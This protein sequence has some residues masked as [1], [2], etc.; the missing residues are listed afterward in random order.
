MSLAS[1]WDSV[2]QR[3]ISPILWNL[4]SSFRFESVLLALALISIAGFLGTRQV[5]ALFQSYFDTAPKLRRLSAMSS[6]PTRYPETGETFT[7]QRHLNQK[8]KTDVP[9]LYLP[10][11]HR[12]HRRGHRDVEPAKPAR[13]FAKLTPS[14]IVA[15]GYSVAFY[16]LSLCLQRYTGRQCLCRVVRAW[17]RPDH[18]RSH[19]CSMAKR[20]GCSPPCLVLGSSL[21]V[22]QPSSS[23][24]MPARIHRVTSST[25]IRTLSSS[26]QH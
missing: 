21:R 16:M 15:L 7:V 13:E 22:S 1:A 24:R 10:F 18:P 12:N 3:S 9:R 23:S 2:L 6:L 26:K 20:Y 4:S 11:T 5:P 17:H 19:G 8:G 14:I 25:G